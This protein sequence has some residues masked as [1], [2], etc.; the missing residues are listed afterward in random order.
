M[1]YPCYEYCYLRS[2]K[3]YNNDC[4]KQCDYAKNINILKKLFTSVWIVY[5]LYYLDI[6]LK[7]IPCNH[8]SKAELKFVPWYTF[9]NE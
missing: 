7:S 6:L 3:Q 4:I 5:V 1:F 8:M 2:G 9:I